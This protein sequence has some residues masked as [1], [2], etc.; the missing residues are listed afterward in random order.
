[1]A[2]H[3]LLDRLEHIMRQRAKHW[4]ELSDEGRRLITKAAEVAF[5]DCV[6][7]GL[8]REA[9]QVQRKEHS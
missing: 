7:V 1:M 5:D 6:E 3:P 4:E 2:D 8:V 9:W